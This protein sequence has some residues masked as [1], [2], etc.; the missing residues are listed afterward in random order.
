[1]VRTLGLV[2]LL[3]AADGCGSGSI[4]NGGARSGTLPPPEVA[5]GQSSSASVPASSGSAP[6]AAPVSRLEVLHHGQP[7]EAF[8]TITSA[9]SP[10]E[11]LAAT[12]HCPAGTVP[13]LTGGRR[14]AAGAIICL[15]PLARDGDYTSPIVLSL[16]RGDPLGPA[17]TRRAALELIHEW[18]IGSGVANVSVR[19][20]TV[21]LTANVTLQHRTQPASFTGGVADEVVELR[22]TLVLVSG[23]AAP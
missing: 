9:F 18:W 22:G 16:S 20:G 13:W 2:L 23:S 21:A 19:A 5:A 14:V 3:C 15:P 10:D 1:M 11:G 8:R 7:I 12:I 4:E 17:P 6:A